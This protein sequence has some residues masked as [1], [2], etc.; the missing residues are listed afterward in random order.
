[1]ARKSQK[2]QEIQQLI[3]RAESSRAV[4]GKELLEIKQR[5][6]VPARIRGSLKESPSGWLLGS[7]ASGFI[8]SRIFRRKP[9][10]KEK[11]KKKRGLFLTLLGLTLTAIRPLARIW[12]TDQLKHHLT[13][14]PGTPFS[15]R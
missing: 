5:L 3:L 4:L 2:N 6:D 10:R 7:M 9:A 14:R 1:M 11:E 12:L 15:G 13:G 8:V